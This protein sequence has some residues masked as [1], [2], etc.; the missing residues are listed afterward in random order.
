MALVDFCVRRWQFTLIAF[1]GLALLGVASVLAI[2]KSEDPIF[3]YPNFAVIAVLPGAN[4]GDLERLVVDPVEARLKPLDGIKA[5]KTTIEDSLAVIWVE[6][7]AGTDT[8][9]KHDDV[10]REID[11]LRPDLPAQL[12]RLEVKE[13]GSEKVRS[14]EL[15]LVSDGEPYS[16]LETRARQL[17]KRLEAVKGI[18]EVEI[19]ALPA[20]EIRI[21]ADPQ[22]LAALGVSPAELLG[23]LH[24]GSVNVPGGAV[25]VGTRQLSV[26]AVGDYRSLREIEAT[27]VRNLQGRALRVSD[28][29]RV[30]QHDAEP[31]HLARLDG[32]RAVLISASQKSGENVFDV[33]AGVDA[34]V[35]PF[36]AGLPAGTRLVRAFDQSRNVSRRMGGFARDFA[37]AVLLVL[38]TLLP[39]GPRAAAVVMVT[40]PLSLAAGV[41]ALRVAGQSINQL[42]I[43]GFVIAL[44][45]LVD[46]AVVVVENIVRFLRLGYAPREAAVLATRQISMAVVGCTATLMLAFVPLMALPGVSGLFIRSM[47]LAVVFTIAAS[48]LASLTFVPLLSSLLVR[49]EGEHGNLFFRGLRRVVEGAYR[50]LLH[51]ALR[52]P[53]AT[54]LCA[55]LLFLGSVALVPRIGVSLFPRSDIPQFLVQVEAPEGASLAETDRAVRF[56]EQAL[57]RHPLVENVVANVGKGNPR[58]YYNV[59]QRNEK[60]NVGELLAT[61]RTHDPGE[62]ARE[63]SALRRE[64]A[65]FPAASL[66]VREFE[67]GPALDAPIAIR[68]IGDKLSDIQ[69]AAARVEEV[70]RSTPGTR[71]VRNPTADRRSDLR[72]RVDRERAILSG[73]SLP[74]VDAAVRIAVG[75]MVVGRYRDADADEAWDLRVTVPRGRPPALPGGARPDLRVL[76]TLYLPGAAG[77]VPLSQIAT[78]ELEPSLTR[79]NHFDARRS[80]TLTAFV[81]DG[82]NTAAVTAD[83]LGRLSQVRL[84]ESIRLVPAGEYESR[85]ESFSGLSTAI[86]VSLMGILAVLVLE[87]R[88]FTSTLIVASVIPLGVVGGMGAL[89]LSGYT[90]SFTA[91][92]GFV[93]L[94]GIE[95]KNSILLV[96]FTNELR[97]SGVPLDQAIQQAGETRFVPILLTTLTAIGGLV[98]LA[99]ERSAL[100][101]PL[102]IVILGGL[103]SSTVLARVVTPVLYKLLPPSVEIDEAAD[104]QPRAMAA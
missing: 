52:R 21:A 102:S 91:A 72:V 6:F 38:V 49:S 64:L 57:A 61:L 39:L 98:P 104:D 30:E 67:N 37:I 55:L 36:A 71:Y 50:P 11:A 99:L 82:F 43:V 44:G 18:G 92:V 23:A 1:A 19:A 80:S 81:R 73:V 16:S 94:M 4:P 2:P 96:D 62:A 78:L 77:A 90:L 13:F 76:E 31:T 59:P 79:I 20:Q 103:V 25:D 9:R 101:S 3:P 87:F 24:A 83:V 41:A 12:A 47:P 28:V 89:F 46:D 5:I 8:P 56:A 88:T 26:K 10:L 74:D 85:K 45:L 65:A 53:R 69:Q 15:A 93:A 34:A 40:L 17:K 14:L 51:L 84:P 100:Y 32:H 33:V 58:V 86:I 95:V 60:S 63:L 66:E 7:E 27:V 22:R 54:L 35:A 70:L 68:V 42:S 75:G 29:A 97:A 48:L